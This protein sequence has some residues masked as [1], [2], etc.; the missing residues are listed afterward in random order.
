MDRRLILVVVGALV[1]AGCGGGK[2][3]PQVAGPAYTRGPTVACLSAH[4]FEVSTLEKDVNFI[5]FAAP[6]GGLRARKKGVD[7]IIA[8]GQNG[9]DRKQILK[10]VH[11]FARRPPIFRYRIGKA[12]IVI[13]WAYRPS[14]KNKALLDRCLARQTAKPA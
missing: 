7:V 9:R 13:L 10:A 2:S 12:N 8:F 5:A 6:G 14:E 1:L 11:R 3:K 4:G